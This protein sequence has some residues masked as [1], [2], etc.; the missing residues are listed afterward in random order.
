M[1]RTSELDTLIKME[2]DISVMAGNEDRGKVDTV[3]PKFEDVMYKS[4]AKR[5]YISELKKITERE[6]LEE[7]MKEDKYKSKSIQ[8][9]QNYT[10][11]RQIWHYADIGLLNL[12]N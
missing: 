4:P 3:R 5:V 11:G 8:A 1:L 6:H 7:K 10:S 9:I 12:Q 2:H